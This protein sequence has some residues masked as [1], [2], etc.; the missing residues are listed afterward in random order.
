MTDTITNVRP[1]RIERLW[2]IVT[3]RGMTRGALV[4]VTKGIYY[5]ARPGVA[6]HYW[7]PDGVEF[8]DAVRLATAYLDG[9]DDAS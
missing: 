2:N 3:D 7:L 6:Y 4:Y 5:V 1:G 8:N 9:I